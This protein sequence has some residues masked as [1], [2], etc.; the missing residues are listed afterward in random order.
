MM[1][2]MLDMDKPE[3]QIPARINDPIA[4]KAQQEVLKHEKNGAVKVVV[5]Q[6]EGLP[7][8]DLLRSVDPYC[9]VFLTDTAGN[10]KN[11]GALKTTVQRKNRNPIWNE[12]F[13]LSVTN[14]SVAITVAVYD[15]DNI[16]KDDFVGVSFVPLAE[17]GVYTEHDEWYP[18]INSN[19]EMGEARIRLKIT[20][21]QDH[22]VTN[23]SP[24]AYGRGYLGA[25]RADGGESDKLIQSS[26][27]GQVAG[28]PNPGA[29]LKRGLSVKMTGSVSKPKDGGN[30]VHPAFDFASVGGPPEM[31][32]PRD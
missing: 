22:K 32:D 13:S 7:K 30:R 17:L 28:A 1:K 18:V 20:L 9:L 8:M 21:M 3:N 26:R 31:N 25:K 27:D 16:T 12:E 10:S 6:A 2:K 24:T 5:V 15:K 14:D 19:L 4:Y 23:V 29:L 11:A